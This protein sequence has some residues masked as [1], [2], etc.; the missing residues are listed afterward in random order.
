MSA[1]PLLT[2]NPY[3]L[4]TEI[5]DIRL[6]Q[7]FTNLQNYFAA[8]NQ[9]LGFQFF[10]VNL[11][12]ATANFLLAHGLPSIPLDIMVTQVTGPGKVTFN[13][14]L[15]DKTNINITT[16]DSARIRFF[17]GTYFNQQSSINANKTDAW[18][19]N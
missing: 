6:R 18:T 12:G 2:Q 19:V 1:N 11:T 16:T 10:E 9:M 13:F 5:S 3:L 17:A 7:N 14:G 4:I 8:N 15:F